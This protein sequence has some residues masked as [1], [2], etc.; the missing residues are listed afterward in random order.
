MYNGFV[1]VCAASP[2]LRVA[3]TAYNANE[4]IKL[5]NEASELGAKL[6]VF[7]ELALTGATCGDLFYSEKLL[8][9]ALEALKNYMYSTSMIDAISVIGVP[10][11]ANDKLYNCAAVVSGGQL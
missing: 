10:F 2:K 9:G 6:I 8:E 1:K 4:C 3:D 7:P 11:C 5:A